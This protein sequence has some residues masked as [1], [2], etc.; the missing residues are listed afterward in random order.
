[1]KK[2]FIQAIGSTLAGREFE[3]K[4]SVSNAKI[5]IIS[6]RHSYLRDKC[7]KINNDGTDA[8]WLI[9][10]SFLKFKLYCDGKLIGTGPFR[11]Q[12]D[13]ALVR[14]TF[15]LPE[16]CAGRHVLSLIFRGETYGINIESESLGI[17][18]DEHW[19][20]LNVNDVYRPVC[21]EFPNV[22]GYYKGDIGPGEY[23]EHLDGTKLPDGWKT[24]PFDQIPWENA[25]LIDADIEVED[26]PYDYVISYHK[27]VSK[28]RTADGRWICDFGQ[29]MIGSIALTGEKNA[30][31]ELRLGEEM[32]DADRV[33]FQTRANTCYQEIW[34]FKGK[35][36]ILE[37]FG[38]RSFRYAEICGFDGEPEIEKIAIYAPFDDNDS[39]MKSGIN[40]LDRIYDLCKRTIKY[41]NM[42]MY[43]DCFSRERICYE[44]DTY[45]TMRTDFAV[46]G[47]SRVASQ[48]MEFLIHHQTWPVEWKQMILPI[49]DRY[50]MHTADFDLLKRNWHLLVNDCS[51]HHLM[52]NG[53]ICQFPRKHI[54][55]WP[56][57]EIG[58]YDLNA[59]AL[60]VPNFLNY[61]GLRLLEKWAP[62]AGKDSEPF[63]NL[64]DEAFAS[65]Q[66]IYFDRKKG[67]YRDGYDSEN[68]S[69]HANLWALWCGAVPENIQSKIAKFVADYGPRCSLYTIQFYLDVL[70]QYGYDQQ[71]LDI[72]INDSDRSWLSMLDSGLTLTA[73]YWEKDHSMA[74][75][76][77]SCPANIIVEHL[78]GLKPTSPGWKS[79]EYKVSP[80]LTNAELRLKTPAGIIHIKN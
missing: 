32:L 74:H 64:A 51:Y 72:L 49:L 31:V 43:T 20:I 17:Y 14:H 73:E 53:I 8:N 40:A 29:E 13:N 23:F 10:G 33:R 21:Y 69:L 28:R 67:L 65:F 37:H 76:W 46:S 56:Y 4:T 63:K 24:L 5:S 41:C 18:A 3:L 36:Q 38:L 2:T 45:V 68:C 58:N 11:A 27:P 34:H 15:S 61:A 16:L 9:G 44:A 70:F 80:L 54:I 62:Y 30:F 47:D 78:F 66:G 12:N 39:Y 79:Y 50:L 1:M 48:S 22:T 75:P 52:Q 7:L 19:K 60:A 35:G 26:A 77:G 71:A 6:D 42:D 59:E 57:H 25:T 55:D